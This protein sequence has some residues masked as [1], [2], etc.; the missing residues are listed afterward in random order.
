MR[1]GAPSVSFTAWR[2][3]RSSRCLKR[4]AGRGLVPA[5]R[6]LALEVDRRPCGG[7]RGGGG[8]PGGVGTARAIAAFTACSTGN[9]GADA[10]ASP[11]SAV[12]SLGRVVCTPIAIDN[13][14]RT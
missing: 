2:V 9:S 7:R 6:E 11:G 5:L 12:R 10:V 13:R 14:K 4:P 3:A 8:G 1:C